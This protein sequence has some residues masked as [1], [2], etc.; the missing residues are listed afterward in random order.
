VGA[1]ANRPAPKTAPMPG[2]TSSTAIPAQPRQT[3][4]RRF[5]YGTVMM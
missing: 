2:R 3:L 4:Q 1:T 5:R